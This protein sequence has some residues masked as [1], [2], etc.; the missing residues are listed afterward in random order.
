MND[1]IS[2]RAALVGGLGGAG[3]LALAACGSSTSG[4]NGGANSSAAGNPP[5]TRAPAGT[6]TEH[7]TSGLAALADIPVGQA[8]AATL[9]GQPVLVA[10]PTSTT[11]ACFSAI[12]THQGC[13]VAPDGKQLQCPCHGSVYDAFTGKNVS[14]PAPAPLTAVPVTVAGGKVMPG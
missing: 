7:G 9:N 3:V 4:G 13:T 2:R 1:P 10:R 11:A 6:G 12:C 14:G 5:A 8:V